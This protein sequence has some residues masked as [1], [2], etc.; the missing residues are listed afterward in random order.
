LGLSDRD[1]KELLAKRGVKVDHG[2]Q[3]PLGAWVQ[4]FTPLLAD[5][6]RPCRHR[7]AARWQVD[8]TH[9]KAAGRWRPVDPAIHQVGQ[10]VD[11]S[12]S[13]RRDR[14][15]ARRCLE[16]AIGTTKLT[17][18]RSSPTRA[19]VAGR[20][21]SAGTG[22]LASNRPVRQQPGRDGPRPVAGASWADAGRK[23]DLAPG[24]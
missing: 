3:R 19:A 12:V 15:P 18:S 2:T 1:V 11:A 5:A 17:R 13:P 22:S 6:A 7:V 23:Q 20:A 16:Q 21:P 24:S 14:K 4:R 10:V 8:Q 9:G